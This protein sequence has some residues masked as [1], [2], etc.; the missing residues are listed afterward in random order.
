MVM[1]D[2]EVFDDLVAAYALDACDPAEA[3]AIDEY[4]LARPDGLAE[5]E[6]LRSAAA[7]LGASE[8]LMPPADVR[9]ALLAGARAARPRDAAPALGAYGAEVDRL[10]A[11]LEGVDPR[12]AELPTHNGLSIRDL[13]LHL[14]AAER[15]LAGEL[16]APRLAQWDDALM[17]AITAAELDAHPDTDLAAAVDEW[18]AMTARVRELA[19]Q[20]EHTVAG[21]RPADAFLIRAF[22]TWTHHDD[23]RRAL[24]LSESIPAASVLRAMAEF[25]VR[26]VPWTLAATHRARPGRHAR[27]RLTGRIV[28]GWDVPLAPGEPVAGGDPAVTVT[29]DV[30]DWCQR[31]ADRLAPADLDRHVE[32]DAA[33]ADDLVFAAPAFAGL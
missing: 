24:G 26:S 11:T 20:V 18:R 29:V 23:I 1:I 28:A 31:F 5:V 25:S 21:H 32:G 12:A 8:A 7:W 6:R 13:V 10:A 30:V 22:E 15:T 16:V 2:K 14:L 27:L 33:V 4:L 9:E 3:A 17:H 19:G